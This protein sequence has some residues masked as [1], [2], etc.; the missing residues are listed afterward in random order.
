MEDKGLSFTV[1]FRLR[2]NW[3]IN[4]IIMNN[5]KPSTPQAMQQLLNDIREQ[6][7]IGAPEADLCQKVCIGCPKKLLSY[8]EL[9]VDDW[10]RA[11][12]NSVIPTFGDIRQLT[13]SA[14]KIHA[15]MVKNRLV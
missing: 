9:E 15:V 10:Q 11:L 8:I 5:R 4:T 12:D 2:H 6:L 1:E 14:Q 3:V 7:P 13:R